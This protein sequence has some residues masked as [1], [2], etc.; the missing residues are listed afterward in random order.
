LIFDRRRSGGGVRVLVIV[1]RAGFDVLVGVLVCISAF[2]CVHVGRVVGVLMRMVVSGG[3]SVRWGR[4]RGH[5]AECL[6]NDGGG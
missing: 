6:V 4:A 1:A 5:A 3:V 2:R